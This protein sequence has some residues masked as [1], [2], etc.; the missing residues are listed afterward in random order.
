MASA[1]VARP[2]RPE[3]WTVRYEYKMACFAEFRNEDQVA[4]KCVHVPDPFGQG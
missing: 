1:G 3:G 4:L 2:L